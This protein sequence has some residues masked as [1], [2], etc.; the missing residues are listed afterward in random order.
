[1]LKL[2]AFAAAAA[3]A[4]GCGTETRMDD[5]A[6]EHASAAAANAPARDGNIAIRQELDAA[7]RARTVEAYELFLARHPRHPLAEAAKA[8]LDA[9]KAERR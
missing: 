8:E 1:M 3:A 6:P 5:P 4:G 7:R 9:L 2:M